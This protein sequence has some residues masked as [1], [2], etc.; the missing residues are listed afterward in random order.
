MTGQVDP[1]QGAIAAQG[2]FERGP[3]LAVGR[4]AVQEKNWRP[5]SLSG[6]DM[7]FSGFGGP[8]RDSRRGLRCLHPHA[9][10]VG[11]VIPLDPAVRASANDVR[12]IDTIPACSRTGSRCCANGRT[13]R[14]R[15]DGRGG[16]FLR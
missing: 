14:Y 4:K 6:R 12:Q 16:K 9:L 15:L 7:Q 2:L 13:L 3:A 10:S 8:R 11:N 5:C 1:D